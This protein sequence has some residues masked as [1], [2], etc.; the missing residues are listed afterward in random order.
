MDKKKVCFVLLACLMIGFVISLALGFA[1]VVFDLQP[2]P[3]KYFFG[4]WGFLFVISVV[5]YF[6]IKPS[7][8]DAQL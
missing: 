2:F 5:I 6:L 7:K 4:A 1:H 8:F 3:W